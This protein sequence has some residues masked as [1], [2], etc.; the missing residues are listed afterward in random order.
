[1]SGVI[2]VPDMFESRR[3]SVSSVT[4]ESKLVVFCLA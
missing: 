1:V 4:G 3:L 2:F